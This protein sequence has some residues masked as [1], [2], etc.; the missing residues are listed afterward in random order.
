MIPLTA[1]PVAVWLTPGRLDGPEVAS[2]LEHSNVVY[3]RVVAGTIKL[4]RTLGRGDAKRD[5]GFKNGQRRTDRFA[6]LGC[7]AQST[8]P[9][10]AVP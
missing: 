10:S 6:V 2:I 8:F 7:G 4:G 3:K 9:A 5:G 1:R